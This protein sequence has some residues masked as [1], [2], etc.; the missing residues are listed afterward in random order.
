VGVLNVR[1]L[2]NGPW[3]PITGIGTQAGISQDQAD[4]RYV[5]V[6]GD[7]MTGSLTFN[8]SP[9]SEKLK[10]TSEQDYIGF[11]NG[12]TREGYLQG[13]ANG[14]TL[15][16]DIGSLILGSPVTGYISFPFN[17]R[18]GAIS[19]HGSTWGGLSWSNG[20]YLIMSEGTNCLVSTPGGGSIWLRPG[21]NGTSYQLSL[22][23]NGSHSLAGNLNMSGYS[24]SEV[25]QLAFNSSYGGGWFM[26]DATYLRSIGDKHIWLGGGWFGSNGGVCIGY[27]QVSNAGYLCDINGYGRFA[28]RLDA[29]GGVT[30]PN[31]SY[32]YLY[33]NSDTNH[34]ARYNGSIGGVEI[35]SWGIVRLYTPAGGWWFDHQSDGYARTNGYGWV[36]GSSLKIKENIED[37]S[38]EEADRIVRGLRPVTF[39]RIGGAADQIGF[40]AEWTQD[41]AP[42]A[43]APEV[44]TE[45]GPS[46]D[47]GKLTPVLTRVMQQMLDRLDALEA[48]E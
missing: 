35:A 43:V 39:D 32:L 10:F 19:G 8:A 48:K 42:Y 2:P 20:Q 21:T 33:S 17:C 45:Q 30:V 26:S 12:G 36:T 14:V 11:W 5:N 46:M 34:I 15:Q 1:L 28:Q 31:G 3:I 23:A 4:L 13:H 22:N 38:A 9:G 7:T 27:N 16:A 25:Y 18:V 37:L 29:N 24:L 6:S 47:Y 40:I 44:D 41:V